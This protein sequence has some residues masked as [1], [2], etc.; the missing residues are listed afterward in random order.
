MLSLS[1]GSVAASV[2]GV[3]LLARGK[4]ATTSKLA[5]GSFLCFGG[6]IAALYGNRLI[7]SYIALL[8]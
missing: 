6:L 7:D 2:Y 8:R 5:F 3:V 4:A 1:I